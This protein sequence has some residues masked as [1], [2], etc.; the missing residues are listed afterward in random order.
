MDDAED[1][2]LAE[3]LRLT[4]GQLVRA[5]RT[6]DTM[7]PGEAAVLGYLDRGGPL[8][9][10][11]IAQ[12]RGVSHQSATKAVKELLGQ[13]FVRAEPHPLDGRKLL[14]H[15]TAAGTD[16]LAQERGR[17]AQWLGTAIEEALG[18]DDRETL[19]AALPLLARLTAHLRSRS[20]IRGA[21]TG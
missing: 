1:A 17:R 21:A 15:L 7:P 20:G 16:R 14:L 12:R 13:G 8:T 11:D 5:V 10:A 9:A 2:R 19:A 6:A 3:E 4:V 18:S